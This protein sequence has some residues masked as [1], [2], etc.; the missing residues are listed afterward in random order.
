MT[1]SLER[2]GWCW[3][4]LYDE[5]VRFRQRLA[6]LERGRSVGEHAEYLTEVVAL[7]DAYIADL[8]RVLE[9][10]T[11]DHPC[12]PLLRSVLP[13]PVAD[14]FC[15]VIGELTRFPTARHLVAYLGLAPHRVRRASLNRVYFLHAGC[16][17]RRAPDT[18]WAQA[19]HR[20]RARG[21]PYK[22][23]IR[24]AWRTLLTEAWKKKSPADPHAAGNRTM[25]HTE[26]TP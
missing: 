4:R 21:L 25:Q 22:P 14:A 17:V 16:L 20:A 2:A 5:R 19:Y 18:R 13:A 9:H 1:D 8:S 3:F 26:T 6:L 15:A 23:A 12:R 10:G 24:C 7:L 11:R